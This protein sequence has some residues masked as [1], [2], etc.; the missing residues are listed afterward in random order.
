MNP[1]A[2]LAIGLLLLAGLAGCGKA[3]IEGAGGS[4]GDATSATVQANA[5]VARSLDLADPQSFEDAKRGLIATPAGQVMG[6]DGTPIWDFGSFAFIGDKPPSTVNPS[7]W[8]QARLNNN[9]GLF[10]V[11]DGI[12]QLRG[13]DVAN[14]TLI[15]GQTGWI[16]IDTLTSRETAAAAMAFARKHLGDRPVSALIFTHSH[17]DHF[18]GALGVISAQ[19]LAAARSRLSHRRDFSKR[20]PARTC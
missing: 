9:V 6:A 11:T 13:F 12:Y 16:V 17:V 3:P 19:R 5:Q 15:E 10:K 7:L 20:P 4:A 18:G 1:K 2:A 8:R 14:I